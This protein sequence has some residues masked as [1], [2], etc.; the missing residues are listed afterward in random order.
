MI[1]TL[2]LESTNGMSGRKDFL[3]LGPGHMPVCYGTGAGGAI[4]GRT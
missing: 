1:D 2:G 3:Y 4:S